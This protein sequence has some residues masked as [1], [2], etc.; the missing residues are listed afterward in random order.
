MNIVNYLN[1]N[2]SLDVNYVLFTGKY[3]M[4]SWE[5]YPDFLEKLGVPLLLR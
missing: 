2:L 1:F 3:L 4:T 5:S